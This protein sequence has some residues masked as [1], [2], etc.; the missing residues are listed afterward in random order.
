M[1]NKI[2]VLGAA[3]LIF[4]ISNYITYTRSQSRL[5]EME[6]KLENVKIE[7]VTKYQKEIEYHET[8]NSILNL[9][10]TNK[11]QEAIS[12]IDSLNQN[13][14]S[15]ILSQTKLNI[16][17][18]VNEFDEQIELS[19]QNRLL[20]GQIEEF[21]ESLLEKEDSVISLAVNV[22][23]LQDQLKALSDSYDEIENNLRAQIREEQNKYEKALSSRSVLRFKT[24]GG[25]D[26]LYFGETKD[27]KA[28][29]YGIG[30]WT[31]GSTYEGFWEKN[32]RN[33]TGTQEW[34]DGEL[35]EGAY[36]NDKR[37]GFGIYTWSN[38]E[39]YKGGWKNDIRHGKGVIFDKN[40][41]AIQAGEYENDKLKK[42]MK[43]EEVLDTNF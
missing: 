16:I 29:G 30:L 31:D 5:N 33:G 7:I 21:N 14:T 12:I 25:K 17:A 36:V 8:K 22:E 10:L 34:K 32:L 26:I 24:A 42:R 6:S 23:L 37:D 15:A 41:K 39:Q 11:Y 20:F 1:N 4:A 35:Y 2:I 40:G 27:G 9:V 18:F 3:I 19:Q 13:D 28:T 38:G 43:P